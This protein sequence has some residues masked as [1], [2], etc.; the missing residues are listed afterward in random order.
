MNGWYVAVAMLIS[1]AV[2]VMGTDTPKAKRI[3]ASR[4]EYRVWERGWKHNRR[5]RA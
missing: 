5:Q 1:V 4:R 3:R 2:M